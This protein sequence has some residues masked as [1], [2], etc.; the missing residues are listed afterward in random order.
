MPDYVSTHNIPAAL[1]GWLPIVTGS[2]SA[3][4]KEEILNSSATWLNQG[5]STD[6][7]AFFLALPLSLWIL[8]NIRSQK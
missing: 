6:L 2:G 1:A 4:R 7:V 3:P 5:Y 8:L